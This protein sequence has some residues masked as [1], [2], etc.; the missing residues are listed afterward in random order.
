MQVLVK[1]EIWNPMH[2]NTNRKVAGAGIMLLLAALP[3]V[4]VAQQMQPLPPV[5]QPPVSQFP[6]QPPAPPGKAK[7][8]P[9]PAGT[10]KAPA[11]SETA[12][13]AGEGALRQRVDQLEEQL[14]DMQVVIGTLESLARSGGGQSAAAQFP[15]SG[16]QPSAGAYSSSDAARLD[17]LETQIR[18]LTAQL[19]QVAEQMRALDGR[20]SSAPPPPAVSPVAPRFGSTTVT[21]GDSIG[22]VIAE[23]ASQLPPVQRHPVPPVPAAGGVEGVASKQL[24][25]TA[26]GHLLQ[27]DYGAAEVVFDDFIK[28]FPSDP[29]VP[30]AQYWLGETYFVRG[31]F[32]QAAEAFLKGYK[33]YARSAKA[34]DSL[35]KLA[36]SLDRLGQRDAACSSYS[37]LMSRFPNAPN[38]IRTRTQ[39]ER[40]RIGCA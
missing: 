20:R 38:H 40:Q 7:S 37:E 2:W 34:P 36:M 4:A 21:P 16:P 8:N 1:G 23:S 25:E 26:Y 11:K 19:E 10:A 18:A 29:L 15:R 22:A 30:N 3:A 12:G 24:Y 6:G 14:V 27:Q 28:R 5:P 31:Q 32:K 9:A 39:S 35:L 13:G 17:G 33:T